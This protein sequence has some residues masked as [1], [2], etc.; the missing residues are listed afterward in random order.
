VTLDRTQRNGQAAF[1]NYSHIFI[2]PQLHNL[3]L[4]GFMLQEEDGKIDPRYERQTELLSLC[5]ENGWVNFPVLKRV[6]RAPKA[7]R[8]LTIGQEG[9]FGVHERD[10]AEAKKATVAE[11]VEV[12]LPHRDTLEK[13][14]VIVNLNY[15]NWGSAPEINAL[16]FQEYATQFPVLKHWIGCDTCT[17]TSWLGSDED[18]ENDE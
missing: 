5:I 8:Q 6:L 7:L 9:C 17:L 2:I 13:I 4:R 15:D 14:Q 16:S 12:L 3:T 1:I 18:D 10:D 11:F